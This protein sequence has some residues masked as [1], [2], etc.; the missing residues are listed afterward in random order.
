MAQ[1]TEQSAGERQSRDFERD[2][3]FER[4]DFKPGRE[5]KSGGGDQADASA[6]SIESVDQ[7]EGVGRDEEPAHGE[8]Q[9]QEEGTGDAESAPERDHGGEDLAEQLEARREVEEI[10]ED[11]GGEDDGGSGEKFPG[12]SGVGEQAGESDD[13]RGG[14]GDASEARDRVGVNFAEAG[15]VDDIVRA[16]NVADDGREEE[17]DQE[18]FRERPLQVADGDDADEGV[19]GERVTRGSSQRSSS[20]GDAP[21]FL[22]LGQGGAVDGVLDDDGNARILAAENH[23]QET[24]F[25]GLNFEQ[26]AGFEFARRAFR[27]YGEEKLLP[28]L[29]L[30]A[31]GLNGPVRQTPDRNRFIPLGH[32]SHYTRLG[33]GRP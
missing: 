32:L 25:I 14:D 16:K 33:V 27:Q 9:A 7:I 22:D 1:E 24:G 30:D 11:T 5:E 26:S 12:E 8:D 17:R 4:A 28:F 6:E 18:R 2:A 10:V 20:L 15:A 21:R 23:T 31:G 13:E 19:H 3:A 29:A